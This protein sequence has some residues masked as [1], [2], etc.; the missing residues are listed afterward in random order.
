[1]SNLL[2]NYLSIILDNRHFVSQFIWTS[3]CMEER[4]KNY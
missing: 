2:L 4:L 3:F 1:M